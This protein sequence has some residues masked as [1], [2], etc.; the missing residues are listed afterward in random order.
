[1]IFKDGFVLRY[2]FSAAQSEIEC[3]S[4]SSPDC[5]IASF[6]QN[7]AFW[8]ISA[9]RELTESKFKLFQEFEIDD[10]CVSMSTNQNQ[11]VVGTLNGSIYYL[12]PD[13]TSELCTSTA[14]LNDL[15]EYG[16]YVC[17]A[18]SD[19]GVKLWQSSTEKNWNIVVQ[20]YAKQAALC[21]F[22]VTGEDLLL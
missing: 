8:D 16:S 9:Q 19:G 22:M 10:K 17:T 18:H 3:I 6:D 7:V 11:A 1:M 20:F 13:G 4:L 2:F 14:K 5:L 12:S 15:S 21:L